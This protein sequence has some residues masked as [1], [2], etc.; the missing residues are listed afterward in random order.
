MTP[1]YSWYG[2]YISPDDVYF[3]D[4]DYVYYLL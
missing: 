2:D 1:T 4:E 3:P